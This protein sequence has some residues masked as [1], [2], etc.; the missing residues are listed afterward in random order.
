MSPKEM[1]ELA[2]LLQNVPGIRSIDLKDVKRLAQLLREAPE[3]GSIEVKGW[4]GTGVI[5]TRTA[6]APMAPASAPMPVSLSPALAAGDQTRPE[7]GARPAAPPAHLKEIRSPMV[8]TFYKAPE[9]GAEAYIKV[10]NRVTAGQTVC[11]IE[12][13]KI[14]NE[15]EA[16][17]TGV[18]REISVEDSQPVEFGQ[19]LF[20]VDPN[21]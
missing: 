11:I 21:G 14:M 9:P 12:A 3:I 6:A 16:E 18:V 4:F 13:M 1:Q 15:I 5:I 7:A 20:R 10:G 19:V 17:I 8:G 2:E